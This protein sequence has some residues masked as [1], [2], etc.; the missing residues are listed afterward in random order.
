MLTTEFQSYLEVV[1]LIANAFQQFLEQSKKPY[2][3]TIDHLTPSDKLNAQDN[4][5]LLI[6]KLQ[7]RQQ[8]SKRAPFEERTFLRPI[9]VNSQQKV[10]GSGLAQQ[11]DL[12]YSLD[13]MIEFQLYSTDYL[14]VTRAAEDF[15]QYMSLLSAST[16]NVFTQNGIRIPIFWEQKEDEVIEAGG[17]KLYKATLYYYVQTDQKISKTYDVIRRINTYVEMIS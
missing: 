11:Q 1:D 8:G 5:I 14:L 2:K 3:V 16:D 10:I 17:T 9:Y 6:Y 4:N 15:I 7:K 12:E 13:N